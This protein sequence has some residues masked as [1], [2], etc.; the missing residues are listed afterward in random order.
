MIFETR[1]L[2]FTPTALKKA[3]EWYATIPN[4]SD[5]PHGI[6]TQV[7]PRQGGGVTVLIQQSGASKLREVAFNASKTL[8]ALLYFCRKQRI[9][10]PRD[11]EKDIIADGETILIHIHAKTKV[12]S[13]SNHG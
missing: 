9:P 12:T 5:L 4:Q 6:I 1:E 3:F 10:V 11:A 2:V 13:P 8:G 7:I